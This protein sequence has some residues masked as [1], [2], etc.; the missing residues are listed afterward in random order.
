MCTAPCAT[1][2]TRARVMQ[3]GKDLGSEKDG[4]KLSRTSIQL[5]EYMDITAGQTGARTLCVFRS[6]T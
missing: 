4:A 2:P 6:R 1:D 3:R 5:G